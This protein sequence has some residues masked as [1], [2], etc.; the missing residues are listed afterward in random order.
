[1][2]APGG[3]GICLWWVSGS[4]SGGISFDIV[5]LEVVRKF[6]GS[7]LRGAAQQAEVGTAKDVERSG[8][9]CCTAQ[10]GAFSAAHRRPTRCRMTRCDSDERL[11]VPA[12]KGNG[13]DQSNLA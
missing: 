10:I 4:T 5:T 2:V 7:I 13:S 6:L 8:K 11:R 1:M 12:N 3:G 9:G